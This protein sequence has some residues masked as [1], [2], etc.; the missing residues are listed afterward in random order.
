MKSFYSLVSEYNSLPSGNVY[1]KF[2]ND[3]TYTYYQWSDNGKKKTKYISSAEC[4]DLEAKIKRREE[5]SVEIK[6]QLKL[7]NRNIVLS[8]AARSY[9]GYLMM[10]DKVVAEFNN[11]EL[12]SFKENLLPLIVKRTHSLSAFLKTRV[13]DTSRTNARLLKKAMNIHEET[14]EFLSLCSYAAS[15]TDNYWFKPKKSKL[16]YKD[17]SFDS[18]IYFDVALKGIM[19]FYPRKI[20]PSPELTTGGS[21]EKGWRKIGEEWWLYKVGTDNEKFSEM[22]YSTLFEELGLPTA[23]YELDGE[24]IKTKNFVKEVNYEPMVSIMGD[25]DSYEHVFNILLTLNKN[26]ARQYMVLIYYD[27]LLCNIDR[28]NENYGL[29]RDRKTGEIISLAPNFD[30]NL[31]LISRSTKL[32]SSNKEGLLTYFIKFLRS[33]LNAKQLLKEANLDVIDDSLLDRCFKRI[34]IKV[35]EES[36]KTFILSRYKYINDEL[37]KYI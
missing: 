29:I 12:I 9:T 1:L 23:H 35:D 10:G 19:S 20:S 25:D 32:D 33:N 17:V 8:N 37:F 11:G 16:K 28:H 13:I 2:I 36:I 5:L 34:S 6:K 4:L 30:D 18:D 24:Y 21:Y 27:V 31:C 26:I 15:L 7:N 3:K 22:F 14:D